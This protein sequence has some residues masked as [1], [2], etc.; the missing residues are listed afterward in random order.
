MYVVIMKHD[1]QVRVEEHDSEELA[2]ISYAA[3]PGAAYLA[4]VINSKDPMTK[5]MN[6]TENILKVGNGDGSGK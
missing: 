6:Q 5:V 1:G 4:R 2:T 3:A